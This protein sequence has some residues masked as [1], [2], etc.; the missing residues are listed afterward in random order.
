MKPTEEVFPQRKAAEFDETGRPH[1]SMFYTGS[2]N[3]F[4]LLFVSVLFDP[5]N[6]RWVIII[7]F[8]DVVDQINNLNIFEDRMIR[9]QTRPDP[10]LKL[11]EF[12]ILTINNKYFNLLF[13]YFQRCFG[14]HLVK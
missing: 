7:L 11:W 2:P 1:H 13:I 10:N 14:F 6:K 5:L 4:K 8:Q 12:H 9:K 3:F